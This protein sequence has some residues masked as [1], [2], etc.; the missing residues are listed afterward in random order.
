MSGDSLAA[1]L[2]LPPSSLTTPLPEFPAPPQTG[3][4]LSAHPVTQGPLDKQA[5]PELGPFS[6]MPGD[7]GAQ[8][9]RESL[10]L[11]NSGQPLSSSHSQAWVG[12]SPGGLLNQTV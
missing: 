6:L 11:G 8:S 4:V 2:R 3:F 7:G 1:P 9:Y 12:A 5:Q 10:G